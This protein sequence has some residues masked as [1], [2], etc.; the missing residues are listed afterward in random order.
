MTNPENRSFRRVPTG[1]Y[2][3]THVLG[4]LIGRRFDHLLDGIQ[5]GQLA[6]TWPDGYT[7]LHGTRSST[8]EDNA[9]V[10]LHN[11]APLRQILLAGENGFAESYLRGDWTTDNLSRLFRLITNNEQ[12]LDQMTNG[13]WIARLAN[14]V[15]H[16]QNHNSLRGSRRNIE[17][18]YDLGN[19]FYKLWLDPSMS[20]S[21]AL[22]R[23]QEESLQSAQWNKLDQAIEYLSP[24]A[25]ANVLEIGCGWGAMAS[26]LATKTG[27]TVNGISL[28]HEQLRY[29]EEHNSISSKGKGARTRYLH[30]DYREVAGRFDHIVSIE[31]FEAVGER[32]WKTYFSKLSNLLEQ[33]GTALLQVIT[34]AEERF[35]TYQAKPD[36]IQ[37]YI[38][39]GGMLPSKT[40]LQELVHQA[41]FELVEVDWFGQS[42]AKTLEIWR[43][44]FEQVAH[45]VAAL[46]F[47]D[48]FLRMWRYY[49]NYCE[50]GFQI[51][52]T[53]VGQL[54]LAK[55]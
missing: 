26:R 40:H 15:R 12:Q 11:L 49:L 43:H 30:K 25:S 24:K 41:G 38:F 29:A 44:R 23:T 10:T 33:G 20:Y 50:V 47:D 35:D 45:E 13:S 2:T 36:F 3:F 17:F 53:D 46:G 16:G 4:S 6:V 34:I 31:M 22:F 37:R 14:S 5:V 8:V 9:Q 19:E 1:R 54:L 28:S 18:H 52:R 7:S 21:S 55:R 42:Y 48:R 39:P 27:C 32:Y 51:E